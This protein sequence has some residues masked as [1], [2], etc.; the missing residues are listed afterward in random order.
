[1]QASI[2]AMQTQITQ[3]QAT[4]TAQA[5]EITALKAQPAA[6][7]ASVKTDD[8]ARVETQEGFSYEDDPINKRVK[9]MHRKS[10]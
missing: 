10:A 8:P 3:L 9:A 4:N 2:T 6:T 1:M 7:P 5:A